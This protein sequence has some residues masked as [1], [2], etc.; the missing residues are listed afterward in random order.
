MAGG[1]EHHIGMDVARTRVERQKG[2]F[3]QQPST[4]FTSGLVAVAAAA[5]L[6]YFVIAHALTALESVRLNKSQFRGIC[7]GTTD[8]RCG[9]RSSLQAEL[10][11][12]GAH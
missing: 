8:G 1:T 7:N 6:V 9:K 10:G 2:L 12:R 4:L 11:L 3:W 5:R